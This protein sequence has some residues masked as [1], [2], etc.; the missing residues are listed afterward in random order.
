MI[1]NAVFAA[2]LSAAALAGPAGA[3][4]YWLPNGP[5]GTTWNNPQGSLLGT[6]NEHILQRHAWQHR[7]GNQGSGSQGGQQPV[8]P[9]A[10]G[11]PSFRLTNRGG[12]T[13]NEIY[14]SAA[15]DRNWG[16]DRL[17]QDV[18]PAG[19]FAL[20]RLPQG[21]CVNDVRVVFADGRAEE[22][23]QVDTCSITDMT[24]R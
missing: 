12:M 11:D 3:Q 2:M 23:R 5:G 19:R 13:I 16:A 4:Q 15:R 7:Y 1:R 8:R 9:A 14:V 20:I 10:L 6:M 22:R 24:F 18:L 17:G 21:Q